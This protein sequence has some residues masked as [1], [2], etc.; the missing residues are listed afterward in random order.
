M[1]NGTIVDLPKAPYHYFDLLLAISLKNLQTENGSNLGVLHH[2]IHICSMIMSQFGF[3]WR[4]NVFII[5]FDLK[6]IYPGY[7]VSTWLFFMRSC[8]IKHK[9]IS[10]QKS[11]L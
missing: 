5:I 4:K 8:Y 3:E 10:V 6:H 7:S 2:G 9:Y 11:Q 1:S